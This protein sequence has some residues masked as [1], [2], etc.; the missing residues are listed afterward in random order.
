MTTQTPSIKRIKQTIRSDKTV[1]KPKPKLTWVKGQPAGRSWRG[2]AGW[3]SVLVLLLGACGNASDYK[4]HAPYEPD[5]VRSPAV[6]VIS[7]SHTITFQAGSVLLD[8]TASRALDAFLDRQKVDRADTLF[9]TVE[10]DSEA[11]LAR[12]QRVAAYLIFRRLDSSVSVSDAAPR[13]GVG[14]TV[15]RYQVVLPG[16]PDWSGPNGI[17][18]A[19]RPSSNWG[20]ATAANLGLMVANPRDLAVGREPGLGDGAA[21]VLGIQRYRK[22]ETKPLLGAATSQAPASGTGAPQ[23]GEGGK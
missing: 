7:V 15:Q 17:T 20:C 3:I 11:A 22:G 18:H 14:L 21:Q 9:L 10:N 12:A 1:T 13:D 6:Q 4:K 23:A 2:G 19:N 5:Q 16:C 8:D